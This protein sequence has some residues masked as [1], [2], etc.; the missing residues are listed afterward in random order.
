MQVT[1]RPVAPADTVSVATIQAASW[2]SAYRGILHDTYLDNAVVADRLAVWSALLSE[3]SSQ[4]YGSVAE[5]DQQ[6]VGFVFMRGAEDAT[7]GTLLDNLH[8]L[9]EFK[10]KGVGRVLV[11]A[12][13]QETMRRHPAI[14][15]YLWVFEQNLPARSFYSRLGGQEVERLVVAVPGGGHVPEWRVAWNTAEHLVGSSRSASD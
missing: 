9:P 3:G 14:G 4:H 6:L 8:V 11:D 15:V 10:G 12:A 7:W 1:V 13:A 2:R 5:I